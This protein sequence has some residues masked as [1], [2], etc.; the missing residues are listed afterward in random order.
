[1]NRLIFGEYHVNALQA[2]L[3]ENLNC[4]VVLAYAKAQRMLIAA[5]R[6]EGGGPR[7]TVEV[8]A[9]EWELENRKEMLEAS[10]LVVFD[11][12]MRTDE[13]VDLRPGGHH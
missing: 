11:F 1:M 6:V 4:D 5:T 2:A 8:P 10:G 12:E 3:N 7:F 13:V 9:A